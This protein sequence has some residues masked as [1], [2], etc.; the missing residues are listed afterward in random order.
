M[1]SKKAAAGEDWTGGTDWDLGLY[2][3]W[4]CGQ[5]YPTQREADLCTPA[6]MVPAIYGMDSV[7][8]EVAIGIP[9][10]WLD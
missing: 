10:G 7:T 5:Y 8:P 9:E 1:G 2:Q 6:Y 3:C 4:A